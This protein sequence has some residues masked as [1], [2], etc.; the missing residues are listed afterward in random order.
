MSKVQS[1][2]DALLN[3]V[4]LRNETTDP[5]IVGSA[6]AIGS[7]WWRNGDG[8]TT[9]TEMYLKLNVNA[10]GWVKQN[11]VNLKVFN[12]KLYGATGGGVVNDAPFIQLAINAAVAAGGGEIYFP[13]G[14]YNCERVPGV[15]STFELGNVSNLTFRGDG[16]AS[17]L[18]MAGNPAL[19]TWYLFRIFNQS[20]HI[21]FRNLR[22]YGFG[23]INPNISG[24]HF[25]AQ[26]S[27]AVPDVGPPHDIDFSWCWFDEIHLG[28]SLRLIGTTTLLAPSD[29][30]VHRCAFNVGDG[31][32]PTARSALEV[33]EQTSG[34]QL[35]WCWMTGAKNSLIDS[36]TDPG[37]P[38][39]NGVSYIGNHLLYNGNTHTTAIDFS[40]SQ[41]N[42]ARRSVVSHNIVVNGGNMRGLNTN[43]F[44]V[45]GNIIVL[46][47]AQTAGDA[48]YFGQGGCTQ[49]VLAG[50]VL[51]SKNNTGDRMM[52]EIG[53][54][55]SANPSQCVVA[56]NIGTAFNGIE[57]GIGISSFNQVTVE[58]NIIEYTPTLV[59]VGNPIQL[60]ATGLV[61][62]AW[63]VDGNLA[64]GLTTAPKTGIN[65]ATGGNFDIRN[66]V[67]TNNVTRLGGSGI[68]FETSAGKLFLDG[69]SCR[70]NNCLAV[71]TATVL[72]PTTNVGVTIDGTAGALGHQICA[73][74]V[75]AGPNTLV[76][77]PV[78][79][80]NCNQSGGDSTT[81]WYKESGAGNTGWL[82]VGASLI[83]FG[84]KALTT[85][86]A[87][88]FIAPGSELLV[89]TT[90]EYRI[91]IPRDGRIRNPRV[92]QVAGTGGGN[93]SFSLRRNSVNQ[94]TPV[95][96]AN[97][98]TSGSSAA[99]FAVAKG[100][101][102]SVT[103]TK[104]VAPGTVPT[105]VVI[106]MELI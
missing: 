69:R 10:T 34:T 12:V 16:Y 14:T 31:T 86:T 7:Y 52:I 55:V 83:E 82:A 105:N 24:Q 66:V 46:D 11:T 33:R 74:G 8:A 57:A 76:T 96:V 97:T 9:A 32:A 80:L 106:S 20:H 39:I 68:L 101:F 15:L 60:R 88:R 36:E 19:N 22:F 95:V 103:I 67:V 42:V 89:E 71:T 23:F 75:A 3:L 61:G 64:I 56:D 102:L 79:S 4:A 17:L 25:F 28:A 50:N 18:N 99:S 40:G 59:S 1:M 72:L 21:S 27:S 100:D 43:L 85:A 62:D 29:V 6:D 91:I 45:N 81:I 47:V 90:T 30:R 13:P 54:D 51:I 73:V 94:T 58:G 53:N 41:G 78:G 38:P 49:F 65:I 70:N 93:N 63:V 37:G 98:A 84:A 35:H 5:A 48:T 26:I 2:H 44:T 77:A 87:A 92:T 104:S